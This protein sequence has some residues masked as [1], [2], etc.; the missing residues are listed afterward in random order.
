MSPR[1]PRL[2]IVGVELTR[3]A[4][5][6]AIYWPQKCVDEARAW[7]YQRYGRALYEVPMA[8]V[9]G[10]RLWRRTDLLAFAAERSGRVVTRWENRPRRGAA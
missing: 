6:A 1:R 7:T 3:G 8:L 4:V 2:G 5:T 10:P 9:V